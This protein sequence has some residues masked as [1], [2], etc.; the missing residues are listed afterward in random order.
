M[1]LKVAETAACFGEDEGGCC[2]VPGGE[3]VFE[4]EFATSHCEVA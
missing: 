1:S 3:K 2:E 4:I